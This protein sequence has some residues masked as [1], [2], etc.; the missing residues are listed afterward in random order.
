MNRSNTAL[1]SAQA[2][3]ELNLVKYDH[4]I[5]GI[6]REI[7]MIKVSSLLNE[8]PDLFTSKLGECTK[9]K[10][11]LRLKSDARPTYAPRRP[12]S[13]A[14]EEQLSTELDRLVNNGILTPVD[15]L[16]WAAPV[17]V[18]KKHNGKIRICADYSTGLNG[19]LLVRVRKLSHS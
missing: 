14:L 10:A 8:F 9:V 7:N 11:K 1:I 19:V 4:G 17:V 15:A 13:L 5:T 6:Q 16:E 3:D 12:V 2:I 18:A